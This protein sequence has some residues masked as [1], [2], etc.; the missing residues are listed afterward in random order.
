M[1]PGERLE[2]VISKLRAE[3]GS[4]RV[5]VLTREEAEDLNRCSVHPGDQVWEGYAFGAHFTT[6]MTDEIPNQESWNFDNDRGQH[7]ELD[8]ERILVMGDP[9]ERG[10]WPADIEASVKLH[11]I[12]DELAQRSHG[13][14]PLHPDAPERG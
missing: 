2:A 5:V 6:K 1:S 12:L 4:A 13:V 14:Q 3:A 9:R 11:Q 10:I 7:I 8:R